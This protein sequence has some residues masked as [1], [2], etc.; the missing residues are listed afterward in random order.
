VAVLP[1][2]EIVELTTSGFTVLGPGYASAFQ[3]PILKS[4]TNAADY[5]AK[6]A[7]D[8]L[9]S[10]WGTGMSPVSIVASQVPLPTSLGESCLSVAGTPIPLI[11]VSPTQINAQLPQNV[12]GNETISLHTPGGVSNTL[13]FTVNS[14][15]PAVFLSGVAGDWSGLATVI[16]AKNN[17]LVTPT[18]P[19]RINDTLV[20]WLT[21]MGLTTPTVDAGQPAPTDPLAQA[22]SQPTVTLG[23]YKLMIDYAGMAPGEAGVYQINVEV[24]F[25]VPLGD[26]Q[27]LVITQ[28]TGKTTLNFRVVTN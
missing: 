3:S 20:I 1:S 14:T 18:N 27:P 12:L 26:D 21:G 6:V 23:G 2:G 11:F 7:P 16:R 17:Q 22:S 10:V 15:A 19:I 9:V 4:I 8:G 5:T 13:N 24:P 28:G 25:G